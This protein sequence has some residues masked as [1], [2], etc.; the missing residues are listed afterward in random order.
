MENG[1]H[2]TVSKRDVNGVDTYKVDVNVDGKV[3]KDNANIVSGGTV[4]SALQDVQTKTDTDLAGKANVDATNLTN[5]NVS[6]WQTKL[7]NGTVAA[8]NAGLV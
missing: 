4:Y 8:N 2:T 3:E 6:A 1:S 7:G 5:D